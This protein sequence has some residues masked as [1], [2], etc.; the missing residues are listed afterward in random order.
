M[1]YEFIESPIIQR[2]IDRRSLKQKEWASEKA[3]KRK[4]LIREICSVE[5]L[6]DRGFYDEKP[7]VRPYGIEIWTRICTVRDKLS[8]N[9]WEE[10]S[11]HTLALCLPAEI[12][13]A[14]VEKLKP[15]F[16][17]ESDTYYWAFNQ[18]GNV[19]CWCVLDFLTRLIN[20]PHWDNL[21]SIPLRWRLGNSK[22][23][24]LVTKIVS[25]INDSG[26]FETPLPLIQ[27]KGSLN[28]TRHNSTPYDYEWQTGKRDRVESRAFWNKKIIEAFHEKH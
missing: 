27:W 17:E 8:A 5:E 20:L 9:E 14:V 25:K 21:P 1:N 7:R 18:S 28:A 22:T 16:W 15:M 23:L 19:A 6:I 2:R 12:N 10:R 26:K 11:V 24:D 4:D 3:Q 13:L